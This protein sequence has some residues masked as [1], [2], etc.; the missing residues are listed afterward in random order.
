[1]EGLHLSVSL[2]QQGTD[3]SSWNHT[4]GVAVPVAVPGDMQ[5]SRNSR[6]R[7]GFCTP[8]KLQVVPRVE[9]PVTAPGI[10]PVQDSNNR[11]E[12]GRR[13]VVGIRSV[14]AVLNVDCLLLKPARQ[15]VDDWPVSLQ[16]VHFPGLQPGCDFR[17]MV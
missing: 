1:M 3:S 6:T 8:D 10:A 14:P 16:P 13:V 17:L 4:R 11:V 7:V 12:R 2:F 15:L 5:E 9:Q